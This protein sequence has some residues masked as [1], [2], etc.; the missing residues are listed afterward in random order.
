[1]TLLQ[2]RMQIGMEK[3]P[4]Q[5]PNID[6]MVFEPNAEDSELFF[7]NLFSF[8]ARHRVCQLAYRNTLADLRKRADVLRPMLSAH[9]IGLRDEI[10]NDRHRSLLDG[11]DVAPRMTETTAR[12][13]RAL[14]DVDQVV[15]RRRA[16]RSTGKFKSVG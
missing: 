13:R 10:I 11:L 14:D 15:S 3:Y 5:F 12:L 4:H 7:T 1:R 16:R 8:S 2:S 9:G 6:Q